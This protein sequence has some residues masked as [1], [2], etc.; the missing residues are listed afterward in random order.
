MTPLHISVDFQNADPLGRVRLSTIG[1]LKSLARS[2]ARLVD[3]LTVIVHDEELEADGVVSFAPEEH[4]WVA[5]I[6]WN[7]IRPI[8]EA[9]VVRH[10]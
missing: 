1:S 3:G 7:A 4:T 6:D 2:G 9:A 8:A 5:K 10:V